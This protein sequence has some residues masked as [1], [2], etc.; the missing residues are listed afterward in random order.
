[1]PEMGVLACK[2]QQQFRTGSRK[3]Q[4]R[5]QHHG[6]RSK[7]LRTE[8]GKWYKA[9]T[10]AENA[11][12]SDSVT[13]GSCKMLFIRVIV[14]LWTPWCFFVGD[15]SRRPR[16]GWDKERGIVYTTLTV[17]IFTTIVDRRY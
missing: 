12:T 11:A 17:S 15:P 6:Q 8:A 13:D 14:D 10:K 3:W 9:E 1:M 4:A 5:S 2:K 7:E 16:C